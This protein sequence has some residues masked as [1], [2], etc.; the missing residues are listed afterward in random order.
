M[1]EVFEL[2]GENH[3]HENHRHAEGDEE[4]HTRLLNDFARPVRTMS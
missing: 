2:R 3:V 1:N 4:V